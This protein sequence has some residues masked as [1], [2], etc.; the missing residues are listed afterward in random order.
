MLL[1]FITLASFATAS[2]TR[3]IDPVVKCSCLIPPEIE[4][5]EVI[6]FSA[7]KTNRWG[8]EVCN[9]NINLTHG[10]SGDHVRVQ[11][12]LPIDGYSGRL[13]GVGG[14]GL[15]EIRFDDLLAEHLPGGFAAVT[16]DAGFLSHA[17]LME[18]RVEEF[19]QLMKNLAYVS[20]HDLTLVGKA[21]A[22]QF[23]GVDVEYA[24]WNGCSMKGR[25]GLV[26]A[27]RYPEDYDGIYA[28][29]PVVDWPRFSVSSIWPHLIQHR[30]NLWPE[31]CIWTGITNMAI[32][33]CDHLDG[34]IDGVIG[35]PLDCG[36]KAMSIIG[37]TVCSD[38]VVT[39]T[40]AKVW[41]EVSG[42]PTNPDGSNAWFGYPVGT[43]MTRLVAREGFPLLSWFTAL[44]VEG[45]T[46]K[47]MTLDTIPADELYLRIE[48]ADRLYSKLFSTNN[49]DLT[50]FRDAGGKLLVWHGWSDGTISAEDSINYQR[51]VQENLEGGADVEDF[52]RLFIAPGV[53]HCRD[54]NGAL[55][56]RAMQQLID[57]VESGLEPETLDARGPAGERD[58]CIWPNQ[59]VYSGEGN[60]SEASS[61][62]CVE[63]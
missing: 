50:Q 45:I 12:L 24:Y 60:V 11:T 52:F 27:Q 4:G 63:P 7:H 59:L 23:Y 22:K 29:S 37:Q 8:L 17:E 2:T 57:W 61:W 55:P 13:V 16:T 31:T 25:P 19:E 54:G 39:E 34:A 44:F 62:T 32:E 15:N 14:G 51:R 41:D 43:N 40:M 1:T 42:G 21:L 28:Y 30:Y 33:A 36:F 46:P 35:N 56:T 3:T 49:V 48:K 6:G 53:D 18:M 26:E 20:T 58:L 10:S 5:A 9:V 38:T 47:E